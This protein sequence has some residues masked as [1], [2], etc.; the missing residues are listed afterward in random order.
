MELKTT[1]QRYREFLDTLPLA[2]LRILGR[3][4]GVERSSSSNKDALIKEIIGILTGSRAPAPPSNRGAPVKQSY[5]DPAVLARLEEI[6]SSGEAESRERDAILEVASG[7]GDR[8]VFDAPVYTGILEILQGGYGFV[9]THNCQPSTTG[10][11]VFVPAS[12]IHSDG[13]REGDFIA[14]TAAPGRRGGAAAVVELLGVNGRPVTECGARPQFDHLTAVF[15]REKIVLSARENRMSLRLLDLFIPIGKGQRALII[16]PPKAGKTTLLKDIASAVCK[17]YPELMLIVLL[18][19]ERPEEVTDFRET[20]GGAQIISSTFDEGAEHHVH[21]A[22]LALEHAKRYAEQGT[23]VVL[24]LDSLTKLTR[25]C[26]LLAENTGKTLSGGLEAGTLTFPKRFFGTAR[27]TAAAGSITILSTVLVETGSRMDDVIYEEFKGTGN[28][29]IFLSRELAER[30]IF[31]ALDLRRSGTRREE[32]LLTEPERA[33]VNALRE[34][35][36]TDTAG[37]LSMLGRTQDNAEWVARLPEWLRVFKNNE[38][39]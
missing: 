8:P 13:L 16:A 17:T 11:D 14:C 3:Q 2:T 36:L 9:R 33:A 18:I 26:N 31:P 7:E 1:E 22:R 6:R 10:E 4:K 39:R 5:L 34:R 30:R 24:L 23:D 35:G 38:N 28:A 15:P 12:V 20:V 29:D 32:L 19:D 21:A 37:V 27:N 25:A